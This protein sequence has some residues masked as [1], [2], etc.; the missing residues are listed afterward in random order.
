MKANDIRTAVDE[1]WPPDARL[2]IEKAAAVTEEQ[3]Q[4]RVENEYRLIE[5]LNAALAEIQRPR[6]KCIF[7]SRK[8]HQQIEAINNIRNE[9]EEGLRMFAKEQG[10]MSKERDI[11]LM[12]KI[13]REQ[14]LE[15]E[16]EYGRPRAKSFGDKPSPKADRRKWKQERNDL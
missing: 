5:A 3:A 10:F 7:P 2:L 12:K 4:A 11:R 8:R 1:R 15:R 6:Y 16:R 13:S 9:A 14:R